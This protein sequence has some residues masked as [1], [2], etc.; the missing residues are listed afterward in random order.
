MSS[1]LP[2]LP[3]SPSPGRSHRLG[4]V[5]VELEHVVELPLQRRRRQAFVVVVLQ[6]VGLQEGEKHTIQSAEC[7]PHQSL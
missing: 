7:H 1:L 2:F 5:G 4:E 6:Q 3:Q